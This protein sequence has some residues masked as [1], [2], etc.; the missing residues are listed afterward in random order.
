LYLHKF[1]LIDTVTW[2]ISWVVAVFGS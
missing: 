2:C 1:H